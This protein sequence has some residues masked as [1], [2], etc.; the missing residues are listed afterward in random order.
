MTYAWFL[1]NRNGA[2]GM[3]QGEYDYGTCVLSEVPQAEF[4][5]IPKTD[6]LRFHDREYFYGEYFYFYF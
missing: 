4:N 3:S 1:Y 2:G 6:E 5:P